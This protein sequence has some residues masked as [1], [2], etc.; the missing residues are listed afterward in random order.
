MQVK[1][2]AVL[3]LLVSSVLAKGNF[4]CRSFQIESDCVSKYVCVNAYAGCKV[5]ADNDAEC[6]C[7]V[8]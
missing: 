8:K 6:D 7:Y 1:A 3:A 2:I 4:V 5:N